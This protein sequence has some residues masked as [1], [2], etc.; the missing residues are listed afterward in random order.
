[1]EFFQVKTV[2]EVWSLFAG[3]EPVGREKVPLEGARG[4][5]LASAVRASED[6]PPFA[7]ATMDGYAVRAADTFG[8]SP[9]SPV[10][11]KVVGEVR[12]GEAPAFSI[13]PEEA[14]AIPTGGM[15]PEGADGVVMLEY[16][17]RIP[18]AEVEVL[19]PVSPWENVM[20]PGEDFKAGEELLPRG[21]RLKPQDVALCA[22]LGLEEIDVFRCPKV[23][24]ISTGDEIVPVHETPGPGQIRDS[25]HYALWGIAEEIGCVPL[26]LGHARDEESSLL[27]LLEEGVESCDAVLISGGSSV[28][29]RDVTMAALKALGAE[30][31]VHGV[32]ISPGKPTLLALKGGTVLWGLPGHPAS[33]T[34]VALV[35]VRP[36]LKRIGGEEPYLP[37]F[38][39]ELKAIASRNI[40]SAPG[41]ED[42]VR[43][44]LRKEGEVLYAYPVFGK[45][46]ALSSLVKG[47]GLLRIDAQKEG[48]A[49][50]EE[51]TVWPFSTSG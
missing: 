29:A 34:V 10:P 26:Y 20:R 25:N 6:F 33:C 17:R 30:V 49:E 47:D 11:L 40:P 46:G 43:V 23:G 41:R 39:Y 18:P 45:S 37:P 35:M 28:G 8:A 13:G 51:V 5:V 50:G 31:L 42:F 19:R 16:T 1:M 21:K 12:M 14:A 48:V 27:R 44:T 15:M 4:R 2:E 22:T 36:S 7:R 38:P 32:A 24:I 3:F 9:S